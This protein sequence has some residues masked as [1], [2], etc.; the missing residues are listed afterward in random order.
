MLRMSK[1]TDYGTVIMSYMARQPR[2]I[3]S[4]TAMAVAVG[5]AAPTT[6][7]ILKT[8]ARHDL[9]STSFKS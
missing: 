8:L 4:V 1:L 9:V 2:E 6:T 3:H 7:K 5:V